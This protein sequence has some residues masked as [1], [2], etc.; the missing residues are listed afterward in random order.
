MELIFLILGTLLGVIALGILILN[1]K[2]PFKKHIVI[3][4]GILAVTFFILS[5]L[6]KSNIKQKKS[7]GDI[8]E[9]EKEFGEDK[10]T[11]PEIKFSIDNVTSENIET[12]IK[13]EIGYPVFKGFT[14]N[15]IKQHFRKKHSPQRYALSIPKNDVLILEMHQDNISWDFDFGNKP[16]NFWIKDLVTGKTYHAQNGKTIEIKNS[17]KI[18]FYG[19]LEAEIVLT[20]N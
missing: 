11:K 2:I 17:R 9:L 10:K 20:S 5:N 4:S 12:T 1:Y 14:L 16:Y 15:G 19:P 8:A 7:D 13:E 3:I 6:H 18:A